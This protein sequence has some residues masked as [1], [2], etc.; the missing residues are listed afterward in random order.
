MSKN[1]LRKNDWVGVILAAGKGMRA[2]PTTKYI[3]KPLM[4]VGG[5]PL[6]ERNIDIMRDQ[7]GIRQIIIVV[8]HLGDQIVQFFA[9][10]QMDVEITFVFQK[11]QKGIGHA[12]LQVENRLAGRR[13]LTILGDELYIDSDHS[14]LL[15]FEDR[16]FAGV[17]IF[18]KEEDPKKISKNF[19]GNFDGEQVLSLVEK[20][21][22][23]DTNLMGL[24][25]Y[26]LTDKIFHYLK[27]TEES[28][29]R[30][31]VEITDALSN[32]A[33]NE[34]V[35]FCILDVDYVNVTTR[36]DCNSANYIVR[37]NDFDRY[38]V[39]VV[40]PAYNEE[41]TIVR[42]VEDYLK[43][44]RVNEVL[45]VDNN[46]KDKTNELALKAG[47]RV[48]SESRQ[49]Y[50]YASQCGIDESKGDII[51]L[52]EG[53]GSFRAKDVSKLLEYLKD[54]DMAI[55]TRTTRQMIEQ[56]ANMDSLVRWANLAFGK[57]IEVLWWN[58]KSRLTDVSCTYRALWRN[59]YR[60]IR[61][62]LNAAGPEFSAEMMIA[63]LISRKRIIEIPVT[64]YKRLE[65]KT[66][67]SINY[68]AKIRN[69]FQILKLSLKYRFNI[70]DSGSQDK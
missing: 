36:E 50:G 7:L 37:D 59:S 52:T 42:V 33:Q 29:L 67:S 19:I 63:M 43:H 21:K 17:L 6:I 66:K 10:R 8:G 30:D 4:E 12:L 22:Y 58:M 24:G 46:S 45:V 61:P 3:P 38:S 26:L 5:K 20:P 51:I 56:G 55:G 9:G 39:S 65:G 68:L 49:G 15:A 13:F 70:L 48:V 14:K 47:A 11:E 41:K 28:K 23:P 64:F 53:D 31:E 18:K 32:M 57:L 40:V 44:P 2:Y 69:A 25:T 60:D 16:D 62:F 35:L 34:Q 54:C 27:H 1:E